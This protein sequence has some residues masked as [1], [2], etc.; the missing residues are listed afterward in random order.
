MS[1][2]E[3]VEYGDEPLQTIKLFY[4]D[5][6]NK[7]TLIFIHGG[8]WRDPNNTFDDFTELIDRF[9]KTSTN[10]VG[11]NYRLSPKVKH[12]LHLSDIVNAISYLE[13]NYDVHEVLIVGHSVGATLILQLLT[14]RS[15]LK[16]S[17]ISLSIFLRNLYF[18][19]GIYDIVDLVEEYGDDYKSFVDEAF[20]TTQE[21]SEAT[22]L[23]GPLSSANFDFNLT[24]AF[25][26]QSLD[27]ELLGVRQTDL[28][29]QFLIKRGA[30]YSDLRGHW[31]KHEEVYRRQ[32]IGE[33]IF[34]SL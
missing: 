21:Y 27:D 7:H 24:K 5:R 29:A 11:I 28:M 25:L 22:A 17:S 6:K 2:N 8:A 9:P 30:S 10:F 31:G 15:I 19:D 13:K 23:R 33:I 4:F 20:A 26:I 3:V 32:E 1:E 18:L 16:S 34:N 14:Y 12:P